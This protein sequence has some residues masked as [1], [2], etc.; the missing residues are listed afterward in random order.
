ME[1]DS[2]YPGVLIS[3]SHSKGASQLRLEL[4][5]QRFLRGNPFCNLQVPQA[6]RN[7]NRHKGM[8]A[9]ITGKR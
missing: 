7:R 4:L 8:R 9:V 2:H 1:A 5:I 3:F 6:P